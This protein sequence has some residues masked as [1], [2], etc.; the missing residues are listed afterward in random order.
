M[1]FDIKPDELFQGIFSPQ[2]FSLM[3]VPELELCNVGEVC[4]SWSYRRKVVKFSVVG[5]AHPETEQTLIASS[6]EIEVKLNLK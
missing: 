4:V 6:T 2:L 5:A 1:P 3:S